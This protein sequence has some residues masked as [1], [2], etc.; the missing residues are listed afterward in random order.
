MKRFEMTTE[1]HEQLLNACKPV[2]MIMLQCGMPPSPQERANA[3]WRSLGDEMGFNHMTVRPVSGQP[4][5]IFEAA[6]ND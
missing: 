6:P 3:A 5:T 2:P 4:E 1:Q